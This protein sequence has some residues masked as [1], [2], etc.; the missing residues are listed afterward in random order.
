MAFTLM[1]YKLLKFR[2]FIIKE[3]LKNPFCEAKG[4]RLL[5]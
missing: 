5:C 4:C 3:N 1:N 2:K